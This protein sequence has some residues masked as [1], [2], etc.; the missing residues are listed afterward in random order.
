MPVGSPGS[1][2]NEGG[3]RVE[4][5]LAGAVEKFNR[6]KEQ[7]DVLRSEMDAFFNADPRPHF[8]VGTFDSDTWEW[9]ERFQI[10]TQP[11]LRFGVILGDCVQ[12]LRSCLDHI[13]WQ[14][15]LLDGGTPDRET[16]FP[17]ASESEEQFERMADRRI[18]GLKAGHRELVKRAQPYHR[19]DDAGSHPLAVLASL[20]NTDK[21]QVLNPTFS[22]IQGDVG[23][24]LDRPVE[25]YRGEDESPVEA[26]FMAAAGT[27]ME[28]DTPWFRMRFRRTEDA[29]KSVQMGGGMDLGIAFG[30]IGL[31]A[32][33]FPKL[34]TYV[35]SLLEAFMRDFPETEFV[36]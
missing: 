22:I 35:K 29:P 13:V 27:R 10:R 24:Y 16:Q 18:P 7:F 26:F 14:V 31:D 8:S 23:D 3:D 20:S 2:S 32:S 17:I 30:D 34:A 19:G 36:H 4:H 11:P 1:A 9:V 15:T 25:S 21:H 5:R 12:N 33:D 28:H 6:S